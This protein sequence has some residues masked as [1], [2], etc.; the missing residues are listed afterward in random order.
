MAN[1]KTGPTA[2]QS[3]SM[4]NL[5]ARDAVLTYGVPRLQKIATTL[6]AAADV[7]SAG[8]VTVN[9]RNV[10][11]VRGFLVKVNG[12]L[13]NADG[14]DAAT[15]TPFGASNMLSNIQF[16]DM[17]NVTRHNCPGYAMA[18]INSAKQPLVLG[19]AYAPNIPMGYGNNWDVDV[20]GAT[21]ASGADGEVQFYYYVPLAYTKLDLRGAMWAGVVNSTAQL[22]L[23]VNPSPIVD[24]TDL[25][26]AIYSGAGGAGTGWKAGTNV[27]VEVWQDYIDQVPYVNGQ[28]FLPMLDLGQMYAIQQTAFQGLVSAQDFGIPF[29]NFRNFLS[30]VVVLDNGVTPFLNNG[31]EVNYFS[32]E[33]ANSSQ[34]WK[35]DAETA[36][37]LA[38]SVFAAD[39]PLGTYYFNFR[40]RP[41]NTQQFGNMQIMVNPNANINAAASLQV[42]FEFLAQLTQVTNASS[43]PNS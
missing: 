38:R 16:Q 33:A 12:T 9:P 22:Q 8:V 6:V 36:A 10:G 26:N 14:A 1:N 2:E 28:P 35:Y 31:D 34:L 30:T 13:T 20:G 32:L 3:A 42:S 5:R 39:P 18:L 17:N 41:I 37:F 11:L 43:L 15:R 40:D 23:T 27:T 24:A 4:Q 21:I 7:A 25:T 19:G 29:A